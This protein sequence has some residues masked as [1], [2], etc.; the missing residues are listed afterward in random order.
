MDAGASSRRSKTAAAVVLVSI[1]LFIAAVLTT[2]AYGRSGGAPY[3]QRG[4]HYLLVGWMGVVFFHVGW[5]A[6]PLLVILW[7]TLFSDGA[8]RRRM[9]AV[10]A[11]VAGLL[12]LS[13][14]VTILQFGMIGRNEGEMMRIGG[15]GPGLY[16]WLA[17]VLIP[18]VAHLWLAVNHRRGSCSSSSRP[19]G[20]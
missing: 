19:T 12:A 4:L 8:R 11:L 1:A 14:P 10:V 3:E 15:F 2:V 9:Y 20:G 17:A 5:Y 18:A 6:N 13:S 16:L 7:V